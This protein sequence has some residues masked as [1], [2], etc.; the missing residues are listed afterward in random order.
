MSTKNHIRYVGQTITTLKNRLKRHINDAKNNRFDYYKDRWLRKLI[1]NNL[2]DN[3]E[4][5]LLETC[6]LEDLND[7][8]IYWIRYYRSL[9]NDM[10]NTSDGGLL[11]PLKG[12]DHPFYGTHRSEETKIK[13]R[14]T[15]IGDKNPMYGKHPIMNQ[16]TKEKISKSLK[17]S[18]KFQKS[19]KSQEYRDKISKSQSNP[20]FVLDN[21]F[22]IIYEFDNMVKCAQL[23]GFSESNINHAVC[24]KRQIGRCKG[25]KYWVVLK[26]KYKEFIMEKQ[27]NE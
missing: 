23:L 14:E 2:I 18:E 27:Q 24:D 26:S 25:Y 15:K 21:N 17:E 3:V 4:I 22:N 11:P 9:Y 8:E 6:K 19:R 10:T 7:R 13:I 16:I 5:L 12:K 1:K 20:V